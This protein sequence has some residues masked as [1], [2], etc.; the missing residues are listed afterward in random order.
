MAD[1]KSYQELK[2]ELDAVLV[3]LQHEDTDIDKAVELH[4]QGTKLLEQLDA[5][6]AGIAQDADLEV[7]TKK[8]D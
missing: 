6:L 7:S 1:K 3:E 8:V 4:K 2:S 5:Y